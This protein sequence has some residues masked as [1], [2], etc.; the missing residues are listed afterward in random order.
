MKSK[1]LSIQ[2]FSEITG[3]SRG[4]IYR[5]IKVEAI[6]READGSILPT[7]PE[8]RAYLKA[9]GIDPRSLVIPEPRF[10]GRRPS[11]APAPAPR[12]DI[13]AR[14]SREELN[15][16]Y[17]AAQIAKLELDTRIKLE[18]W[19][20]LEIALDSFGRYAGALQNTIIR[21]LNTFLNDMAGEI[22]T[23][24]ECTSDVSWK[25]E[26]MIITML[27]D[28]RAAF[29]ADLKGIQSKSHGSNRDEKN[30]DADKNTEVKKNEK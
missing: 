29:F 26:K 6:V 10:P 23:A 28:A 22:I 25:A 4:T 12:A 18:K 3:R 21:S 2:Q 1:G 30:G 8:N 17:K 20:P 16:A 5:E 27:N 9:I 14:L 19:L 11:G 24:G 7:R 13:A 15:R